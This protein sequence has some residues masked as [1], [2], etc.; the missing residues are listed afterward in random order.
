MPIRRRLS[1]DREPAFRPVLLKVPIDL[2][3]PLFLGG[4]ARNA[5]YKWVPPQANWMVGTTA[6][7]GG[8]APIALSD[9]FVM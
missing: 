2:G 9:C 3:T 7:L 8:S 1:F 4:M 5:H 6:L